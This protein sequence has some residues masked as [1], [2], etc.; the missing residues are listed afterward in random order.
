MTSALGMLLSLV[1][2]G[3]CS[4]GHNDAVGVGF[5][6]IGAGGVAPFQACFTFANYYKSRHHPHLKTIFIGLN[7]SMM[8][9]S[10][11]IYALVGLLRVDLA[12][13][14][15]AYSVV[16][17]C[18]LA[19]VLACFP[20]KPPA[21]VGDPCRLPILEWASK[22]ALKE[23]RSYWRQSTDGFEAHIVPMRRTLLQFT[24][25]PASLP[26]DVWLVHKSNHPTSTCRTLLAQADS[27]LR[28]LDLLAQVMEL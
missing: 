1:G 20:S 6:L 3:L 13:F 9:G 19:A 23:E 18:G 22:E 5:C 4:L 12:T 10:G 26:F 28:L 16:A 27:R 8:V 17:A 11:M 14:F 24:I 2:N 15:A 7:S 25:T 21:S